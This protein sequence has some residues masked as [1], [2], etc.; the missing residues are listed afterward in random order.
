MIQGGDYQAQLLEGVPHPEGIPVVLDGRSLDMNFFVDTFEA[1]GIPCVLTHIPEN[2][3]WRAPQEWG[4]D[5]LNNS[6]LRDR[7]FKCGEDDDGKSI[8]M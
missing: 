2:E 1:R 5:A 3:G 8:R 6:S 7:Y 4:L